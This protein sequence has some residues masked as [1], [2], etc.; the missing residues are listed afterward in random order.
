[1]AS[2]PKLLQEIPLDDLRAEVL[3]RRGPAIALDRPR[4]ARRRSRYV[5]HV[6]EHHRPIPDDIVAAGNR[7]GDP[8][9][10]VIATLGW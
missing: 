7:A 3:R 5:H 2:R 10:R 8:D 6:D 1:M 4:S 9:M